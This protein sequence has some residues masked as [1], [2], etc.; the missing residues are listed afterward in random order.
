MR[1]YERERFRTQRRERGEWRISSGDISNIISGD[2]DKL[3]RHAEDLGRSLKGVSASQIRNIF[4]Y[5]DSMPKYDK[6]RLDTLRPKV[7]YAASKERGLR[8]FCEVLDQA[9]PLVR[10][11]ETFKNFRAFLE[12]ILAYHKA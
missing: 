6:F 11:E 5:V 3:V 4:N 10:D 9:I 1:G 12:A 2:S 7:A 8:D